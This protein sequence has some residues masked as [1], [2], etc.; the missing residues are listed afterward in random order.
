[1]ILTK[2]LLIGDFIAIQIEEFWRN[3]AFG[4]PRRFKEL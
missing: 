3:F 2:G 4:P 1:M